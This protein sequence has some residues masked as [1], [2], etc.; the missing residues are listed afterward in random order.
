VKKFEKNFR[1]INKM[2]L[3]ENVSSEGSSDSSDEQV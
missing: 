2:P 3:E 1:K